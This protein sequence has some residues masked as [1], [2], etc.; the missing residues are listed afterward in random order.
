MAW[1]ILF[2]SPLFFPFSYNVAHAQ[3]LLDF[4]SDSWYTDFVVI[5]RNGV[6]G[7][8]LD[9]QSMEN[10]TP[11]RFEARGS[12]TL[13]LK[14]NVGSSAGVLDFVQS[15]KVWP[16]LLRVFSGTNDV[17][18]QKNASLR[19]SDYLY[20]LLRR[21]SVFNKQSL[22]CFEVFELLVCRRSEYSSRQ[23][24]DSTFKLF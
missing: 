7:V 10:C 2:F 22:R 12:R 21:L 6:Y 8:Y 9:R 3:L 13:G 20:L 24:E 11:E 5:Q 16:S 18:V 19:R 14:S 15:V 4:H 1:R 17:G 23:V